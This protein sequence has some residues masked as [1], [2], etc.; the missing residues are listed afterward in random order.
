MSCIIQ[1]Q[2]GG[3]FTQIFTVGNKIM[4][5]IL[6]KDELIVVSFDLLIS[7]NNIT[8]LVHTNS[9]RRSYAQA[10]KSQLPVQVLMPVDHLHQ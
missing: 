4:L 2:S 5:F 10:L 6:M 7:L 8:F 3:N 1:L 9:K